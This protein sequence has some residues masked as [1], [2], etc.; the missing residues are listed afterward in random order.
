MADLRMPEGLSESERQQ[1]LEALRGQL[2]D[3]TG[4][5]AGVVEQDV[6]GEQPV[7]VMWGTD[8]LSTH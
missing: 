6:P 2:I 4:Q 3:E 1:W 7:W 5:A 8:E